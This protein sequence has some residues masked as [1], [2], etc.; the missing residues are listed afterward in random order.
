MILQIRAKR[1]AWEKPNGFFQQNVFPTI[2]VGKQGAISQ[3][4]KRYNVSISKGIFH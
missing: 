3:R 4:K 1:E 2:R